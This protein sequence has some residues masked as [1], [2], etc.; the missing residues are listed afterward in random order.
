MHNQ[1]HKY[2][3]NNVI[4]TYMNRE[5]CIHEHTYIKYAHMKKILNIY[6]FD[7]Y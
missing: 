4:N 1:S 2:F 3:E 7:T 5:V 6:R